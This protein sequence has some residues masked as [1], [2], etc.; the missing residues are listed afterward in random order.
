MA[1]THMAYLR[2]NPTNTR[3]RPTMSDLM[4]VS[5][6]ASEAGVTDRAVRFAIETGKLKAARAGEY[7]VVNRSDFEAWNN[8]R[9]RGRPKTPKK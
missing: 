8:A 5:Q 4:S 9:R 7:W 6:V 1:D 3:T 2:R